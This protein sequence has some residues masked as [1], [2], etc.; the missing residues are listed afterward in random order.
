MCNFDR[1]YKTVFCSG[2]DYTV[3]LYFHAK[4]DGQTESKKQVK[5]LHNA[6]RYFFIKNIKIIG[7]FN[8]KIS[9]SCCCSIIPIF[10]IYN[11]LFQ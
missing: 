3:K 5:K 8:I 2:D 11:G 7:L 6:V 4:Y 10:L 1:N 9:Y